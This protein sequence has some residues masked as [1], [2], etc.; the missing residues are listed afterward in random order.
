MWGQSDFWRKAMRYIKLTG[1][2]VADCAAGSTAS[3]RADQAPA[4]TPARC[5]GSPDSIHRRACLLLR[6]EQ[7]M[8]EH[9]MT[10]DEFENDHAGFDGL[11][12][13]HIIGDEQ[14]DSRHLNRP[15]YRI[16]LIVFNRDAG[17]ERR[18]DRANVR[19]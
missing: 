14:A 4:S 2:S 13:T 19:R 9:A 3:R 6:D 7:A 10:H 18:L 8:A 12:E 17:S 11:S 5:P 15:E 16:K 1:E